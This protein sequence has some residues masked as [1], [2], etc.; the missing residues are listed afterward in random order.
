MKDTFVKKLICAISFLLFSCLAFGCAPTPDNAQIEAAIRASIAAEE[1]PPTLIFAD[2]Q[3]PMRSA[4]KASSVLWTED[5]T[6]QRNYALAYDTKARAFTVSSCSTSRLSKEGT[7]YPAPN[8]LTLTFTEY[9]VYF[10]FP[11]DFGQ[12]YLLVYVGEGDNL[13]ELRTAFEAE[14]PSQISAE[15]LTSF[16]MCD[17]GGNTLVLFVPRYEGTA[18]WI[19]EIEHQGDMMK[20]GAEVTRFGDEPFY[21]YCDFDDKL[22]DYEIHIALQ[23]GNE[24]FFTTREQLLKRFKD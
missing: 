1:S 12:Q 23:N 18:V 3:I 20:S 17:L 24:H 21:I 10:D 8:D 15:T 5:K 9:A 14:A 2:M 4:G 11:S 13:L 6:I 22:P 16:E 19:N 7:Y